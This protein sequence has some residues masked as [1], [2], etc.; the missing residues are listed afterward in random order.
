MKRIPRLCGLG[1]VL[2]L[3]AQVAT[4]CQVR[5]VPFPSQG[6]RSGTGLPPP[7]PGGGKQPG[8]KKDNPDQPLATFGGTVRDLDVKT[9]TV[10]GPEAKTMQFACSRKTRYY[11]GSKKIKASAIERGN[12][13]SVDATRAPDGGLQAVNVRLVHGD[14]K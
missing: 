5:R 2:L 8:N 12:R 13:V 6:G 4:V 14:T 9:L 1:L 10:D 11:D 3:S 7:V